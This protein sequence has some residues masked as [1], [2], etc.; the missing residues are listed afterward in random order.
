MRGPPY[1]AIRRGWAEASAEA[2]AGRG[3]GPREMRERSAPASFVL[4][5]APK[6]AAASAQAQDGPSLLQNVDDGTEGRSAVLPPRRALLF[7]IL[8]VMPAFA[9]CDVKDWYNQNGTV[10]VQLEIQGAKGNHLDEFRS[11]KAAIYGVMLKQSGESLNLKQFTFGTDPKIIDIVE[12]GKKAESIGLT[13]FKTNLRATDRV[14]IRM[15]VFEAIDAAG[16]SMQVCKQT[17]TPDHFP[18]FY[19]PDD[20]LL[21]F[22][23]DVEQ[24]SFAPPR[25]GTV[26]VHFPLAVKYAQQGRVAEYFLFADPALV[27]L[28]NHR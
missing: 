23:A 7:A 21:S 19:Q 27:T 3:A 16:N 22:Q 13:E 24:K 20:D 2:E 18:C 10:R 17:D 12:S 15:A 6:L 1:E 28:E 14:A 4:G 11:I 26:I 5:L 8:L 9:G 25:G